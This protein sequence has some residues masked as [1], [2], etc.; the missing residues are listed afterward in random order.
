MA[1]TKAQHDLVGL[2]A[3]HLMVICGDAGPA[4]IEEHGRWQD[5]EFIQS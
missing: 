4:H 5:H 3:R 1:F 2:Q